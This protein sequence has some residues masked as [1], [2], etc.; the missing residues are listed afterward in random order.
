[1]NVCIYDTDTTDTFLTYDTRQ[2]YVP[3]RIPLKFNFDGRADTIILELLPPNT[4]TTK[5]TTNSKSI[6]LI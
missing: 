4:T 5:T 6:S 1:M 2:S 3:V